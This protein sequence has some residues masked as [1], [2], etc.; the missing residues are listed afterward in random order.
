MLEQGISVAIPMNS[1]NNIINNNNANRNRKVASDAKNENTKIDTDKNSD[2]HET[3]S[4][5]DLEELPNEEM[6]A[7]TPKNEAPTT[8][9]KINKNE[10]ETD[11]KQATTAAV[12]SSSTSSSSSSSSNESNTNL[13]A[14]TKDYQ[15]NI[16]NNYQLMNLLVHNQQNPVFLNL[17]NNLKNSQTQNLEHPHN[18]TINSNKTKLN[19]ENHPE[20]PSSNYLNDLA[21]KRKKK[22][23]TNRAKPT[24]QQSCPSLPQRVRLPP[25]RYQSIRVT[26]KTTI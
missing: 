8:K 16:L 25:P 11:L 1:S 24:S 22:N 19:T 6:N 2:N 7:Q 26:T 18:P 17:L 3:D 9:T 14:A 21:F 23:P 12:A 20:T 15:N 13:S 5:K 10:F 4:A